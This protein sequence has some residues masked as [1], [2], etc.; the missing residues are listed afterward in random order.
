VG[1][2]DPGKVLDDLVFLGHLEETE[3]VELGTADFS[4]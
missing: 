1:F 4:Q 3:F 2:N